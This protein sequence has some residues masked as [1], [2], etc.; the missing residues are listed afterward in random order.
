MTQ[1]RKSSR[2]PSNIVFSNTHAG[3]CWLLASST[4]D[5]SA[6]SNEWQT[7]A[8]CT[9]RRGS[10]LDCEGQPSGG[11]RWHAELVGR[12]DDYRLQAMRTPPWPGRQELA[13][14]C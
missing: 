5:N 14:A 12:G 13:G 7:P 8:D 11:R 4:S 10:S 6:L 1:L 3:S 2:T 9:A